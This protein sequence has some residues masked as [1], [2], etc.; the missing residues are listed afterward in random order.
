MEKSLLCV[1]ASNIFLF[2]N[3]FYM[4]VTY[5]FSFKTD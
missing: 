3:Y 5:S 1:I 2:S 4:V